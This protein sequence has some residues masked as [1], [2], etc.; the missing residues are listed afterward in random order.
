M[1][2]PTGD[3]MCPVLHHLKFDL[4]KLL[5]APIVLSWLNVCRKNCTSGMF[6]IY[7]LLHLMAGI[8]LEAWQ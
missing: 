4:V 1:Q 5:A 2:T 3:F 7:C 8:P 6:L